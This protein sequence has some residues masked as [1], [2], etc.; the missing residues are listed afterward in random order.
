MKDIQ[1]VSDQIEDE[2]EDAE[3]YIKLAMEYRFDRPSL[4]ATYCKLSNGEME[5]V[6]ELHN[7]V[8]AMISEYKKEHGEPPAE[9]QW[10]YDYL[11]KKHMEKA[12]RIK[13][14]Q[15]LFKM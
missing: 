14:M 10:R 3:N 15:G 11:H 2:L 7:Q 4:S 13:V 6:N 12:D 1:M 5:H 9:M 8:V